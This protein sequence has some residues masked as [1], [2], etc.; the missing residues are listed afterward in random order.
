MSHYTNNQISPELIHSLP[1][2]AGAYAFSVLV[3]HSKYAITPLM[4]YEIVSKV[5]NLQSFDD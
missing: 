3:S 1:V 5:V 4:L 2:S